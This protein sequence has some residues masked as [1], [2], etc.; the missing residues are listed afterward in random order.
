M[1]EAALAKRRILELYLNLIEWGERTYGAEAAARR[2]FGTAPPRS[3]LGRR[4]G[5]PP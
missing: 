5:S 4:L 2:H 1:L 3:T